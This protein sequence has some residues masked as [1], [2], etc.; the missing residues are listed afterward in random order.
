M[1]ALRTFVFLFVILKSYF[2][3]ASTFYQIQGGF[4]TTP[5]SA[6]I[7]AQYFYNEKLWG[8][9]DGEPFWKYG[10][11]R[12]GGFAALHGQVGV[13]IEVFPISIWQIQIQRSM[14]SRFYD[15]QTIDCQ[16]VECRGVLQRGGIKTSLALAYSDYFLVPSYSVTDLTL[17]SSGKNFSSEEDNLIAEGPGDQLM[18]VQWALGW[19]WREQKWIL[20]NK[21]SRMVRSRDSNTSQYLIWSQKRGDHLNYF[22]GGGAYQSNHLK[23]SLSAVM[24]VNWSLGENLSLF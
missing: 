18:M 8:S 10:F 6:S 2:V 23:S 19:K 9:V 24:G 22:L 20:V 15:T 14:T 12:V 7:E 3:F 17:N 4:R 5:Q 11:W 21:Q 13:K 16:L 1:N